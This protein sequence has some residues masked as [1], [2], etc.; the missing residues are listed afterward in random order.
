[1]TEYYSYYLLFRG[2]GHIRRDL[3]SNLSTKNAY[4]PIF[5][6]LGVTFCW[7][8]LVWFLVATCSAFWEA[9]SGFLTDKS[10]LVKR[11]IYITSPT[12]SS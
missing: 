4:I 8:A 1:M 12:G 10:T 9:V 2:P 11:R 3:S 7:I 6:F 5:G